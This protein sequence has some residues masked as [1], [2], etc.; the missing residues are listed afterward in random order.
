M[1]NILE[2]VFNFFSNYVLINKFKITGNRVRIIEFISYPNV[3]ISLMRS[4]NLLNNFER[5]DDSN[6]YVK[7]RFVA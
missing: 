3:D 7:I 2:L 4:K 5:L 6:L 1:I